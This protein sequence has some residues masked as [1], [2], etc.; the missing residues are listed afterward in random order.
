MLNST[1]TP[2]HP[3]QLIEKRD[4]LAAELSNTQA[5][6]ATAEAGLTTAQAERDAVATERDT[7]RAER[8]AVATERDSLRSENEV[9]RAQAADFNKRL[10]AEL[11]KLGVRKE[12]VEHVEASNENLT[13]TERCRA[14]K[15]GW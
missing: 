4:R 5:R 14:E 10:S 8:D 3:T 1:I 12:A 15:T 7:L 2:D 11:C 9:M 6:L 13:L